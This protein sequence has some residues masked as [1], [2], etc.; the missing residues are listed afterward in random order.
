M[1]I[2][3]RLILRLSLSYGVPFI[4]KKGIISI[5]PLKSTRSDRARAKTQRDRKIVR[6]FSTGTTRRSTELIVVARPRGLAAGSRARRRRAPARPRP[7][8]AQSSRRTHGAAPP[9]RWVC[10]CVGVWRTRACVCGCVTTCV[11]AWMRGCV[12]TWMQVVS[13]AEAHLAQ[14]RPSLRKRQQG[15]GDQA[16]CGADV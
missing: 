7:R 15:G 16:M 10:G 5:L 11:R 12:D 8:R 4:I 3:A 14:G 2:G 6:G 1:W 9:V 13:K